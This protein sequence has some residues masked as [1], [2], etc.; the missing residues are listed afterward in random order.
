[1]TNLEEK[2]EKI[3]DNIEFSTTTREELLTLIE[4]EK[5]KAV[6]EVIKGLRKEYKGQE[7][8]VQDAIVYLK[9]YLKN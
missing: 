6:E 1:M 3:I 8:Q 9:K 5:T 4:Q 2:I 7:S